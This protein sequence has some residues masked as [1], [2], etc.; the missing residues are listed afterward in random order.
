MKKFLVGLIVVIVA[1]G[2]AGYVKG[3]VPNTSPYDEKVRHENVMESLKKMD[4]STRNLN[5]NF[6]REYMTK[7]RA[8]KMQ[9]E[10]N[11]ICYEADKNNE[12]DAQGKALSGMCLSFLGEYIMIETVSSNKGSEDIDAT[13]ILLVQQVSRDVTDPT[14]DQFLRDAD[15]EEAIKFVEKKFK[16]FSNRYN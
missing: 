7:D 14:V 16:N 1:L 6:L 11:D 5:A 13:Q 15:D 9:D 3:Y 12:D 10:I 2:S 4:E 8:V